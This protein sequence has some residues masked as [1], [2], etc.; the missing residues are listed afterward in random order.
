MNVGVGMSVNAQ[1]GE[2]HSEIRVACNNPDP[3]YCEQQNLKARLNNAVYQGN[4]GEVRALLAKM[5]SIRYLSPAQPSSL[6]PTAVEKGHVEIVQALLDKG[7]DPLARDDKGVSM[8]ANAIESA[9]GS[10]GGVSAG[11][12]QCL[13][14]ALTKARADGMLKP[15]FP[16]NASLA[17]YRKPNPALLKFLLDNGADPDT[18]PEY[19]YTATEEAFRQNLPEMMKIIFKAKP[20]DPAR[21]LDKMAYRA[22]LEKK[23]E[24]LAM[25]HTEGGSHLRYAKTDPQAL[26]DALQADHKIEELEFVLKSGAN[27]NAV[28]QMKVAAISMA[29]PYPDKL[30]LMINH[31]ADVNG[32]GTTGETP[33]A[34]VLSRTR[35]RGYAPPGQVAPQYP[36][37]EM[38]RLLLDHGAHVNG[39]IGGFGQFGALGATKRG[40]T[41]I[42]QLLL[43]HGATLIL[44]PDRRMV[45]AMQG[46]DPNDPHL[47]MPPPIGPVTVA[48]E[49]ERDDLALAILARD[50][51]VDPD[52]RLAVVKAA[53][54]GWGNVVQA[55][56][57]AGADPKATGSDGISALAI[58][59]YRHDDEMAQMLIAAGAPA[60]TPPA[61]PLYSAASP[62]TSPYSPTLPFPRQSP[63]E[64]LVSNEI[65]RATHLDPPGFGLANGSPEQGAFMFYGKPGAIGSERNPL[66]PFEQLKCEQAAN[67]QFVAHANLTGGIKVGVCTG[68][69]PRVR[70]LA[71]KAKPAFDTTLEML[72]K[73]G[74]KSDA[75]TQKRF[76]LLYEKSKGNGGAEM[77]TF[78]VIVIGHGL[79]FATTVVVISP[80]NR[81]AAVVQ[82][83]VSNLCENHQMRI[84]LCENTRATLAD[85]AQRVLRD[86]AA[87]GK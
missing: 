29:A 55:L 23:A 27:P 64:V 57:R 45:A 67:F 46:K 7:A 61:P 78:P 36:V 16:L 9:Q 58:A 44:K 18:R 50:K 73:S 1:T 10:T 19:G 3:E 43:S 85:I 5:K 22:F 51:K 37:L 13:G 49:M 6:L 41:E 87:P 66:A 15:V 77:Y 2:T 34:Y 83:D 76:G 42:I 71:V 69:V 79:L 31:G 35:M 21:N 68:N 75:A 56:L 63:F 70:E 30:R 84:P 12:Y 72:S 81:R 54:K 65:D 4:A 53:R 59:K 26:F 24:M 40:D 20:N 38:T 17:F 82:A 8:L 33:L 39:S 52:D 60:S 74:M 14:L 47:E 80:D 48:L 11:M 86:T 62:N 28:N 25:L 32:G